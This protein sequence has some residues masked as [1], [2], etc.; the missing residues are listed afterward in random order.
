MQKLTKIFKVKAIDFVKFH[1][2]YTSLQNIDRKGREF[3]VILPLIYHIGF[4]IDSMK[5]ISSS[6]RS[7]FV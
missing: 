7:Y 5:D 1:N 6:D 2:N 3:V 4:I